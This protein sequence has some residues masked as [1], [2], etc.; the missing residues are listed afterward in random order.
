MNIK[1]I[2]FI[3]IT[4]SLTYKCYGEE[5]Y[6]HCKF[7]KTE[8]DLFAYFEE[9][10]NWDEKFTNTKSIVKHIDSIL[11]VNGDMN[12]RFHLLLVKS[13]LLNKIDDRL[14]INK[15]LLFNPVYDDYK[16]KHIYVNILFYLSGL[17][18][19]NDYNELVFAIHKIE[20]KRSFIY[21]EDLNHQIALSY[22]YLER[23]DLS[24]VYY[25]F[26]SSKVDF[27]KPRHVS[28]V[29]NNIGLC[30]QK[31][32]Q[33]E[34]AKTFFL[35]AIEYWKLGKEHGNGSYTY[36]NL[37]LKILENNILELKLDPLHTDSLIFEGLKEEMNIAIKN[38]DLYSENL[39]LNL[40]IADFAG[41]NMLFN[42]ANYYLKQAEGLIINKNGS[43]FPNLNDKLK[44]QQLIFRKKLYDNNLIAD[45]DGFIRIEENIHKLNEEKYKKFKETTTVDI[46]KNVKLLHTKEISLKAKKQTNKYLVIILIVFTLLLL[47]IVM[48]LHSKIKLNR[49]ISVQKTELEK[50]L[51]RSKFLLK[52][53][54]HRVKNN[55][56][57]MSSLAL[58]EHSNNPSNFDMNSYEKKVFSLSIIHDFLYNSENI[59]EIDLDTYLEKL[60]YYLY[61]TTS[62][63]FEYNLNLSKVVISTDD[64][65]TFGLLINELIS[66]TLKHCI[67]KEGDNIQINISLFRIDKWAF[68]Y[69]D[70]GS[71]FIDKVHS[72]SFGNIILSLLIK[73]LNG[74]YEIKIKHGYHF[75]ALIDLKLSQHQNI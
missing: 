40:K 70:N 7:S 57:L 68:S 52:E 74:S 41:R 13:K 32:E 28:S 38:N 27:G 75:Y 42:E 66:N 22:Y 65:I 72:K 71:V 48:L 60:I 73:N 6:S 17:K 62:H 35:K 30:Y 12:E 24:L 49:K 5:G 11:V 56:Q 36:Y 63:K 69:Q 55:L 61:K 33:K 43:I 3:L 9:K 8:F 26:L 58:I 18:E 23:Y 20:D 14:A 1:H 34:K 31:L 2:L 51:E 45:L 37:F 47:L 39:S 21:P 53:I 19:I 64:A 15:D 46:E 67:P 54:H 50:A 59:S 29:Y 10:Y 25:L 16:C 4:F 44:Y